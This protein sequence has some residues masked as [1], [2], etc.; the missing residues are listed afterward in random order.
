[1]KINNVVID[2][3]LSLC[4]LL[5]VILLA[6]LLLVSVSSS[7]INT[8][9]VDSSTS[10]IYNIT[11]ELVRLVLPLLKYVGHNVYIIAALF[12]TI[13]IIERMLLKRNIK[14]AIIVSL[15]MSLIIAMLVV[16][17]FIHTIAPSLH[18]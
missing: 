3:F 16:L 11:H 2:V 10:S 13:F 14:L 18:I 6:S 4:I 17:I 9:I 8:Q 1:M 15:V 5:P 12:I 7:A